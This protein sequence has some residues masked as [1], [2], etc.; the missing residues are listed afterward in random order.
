MIFT[1][2]TKCFYQELLSDYAH[3][4]KKAAQSNDSRLL[5]D[6]ERSLPV[7]EELFESHR[8]KAMKKILSTVL[9][10][11]LRYHCKAVEQLSAALAALNEVPTDE[12]PSL[13]GQAS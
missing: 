10:A 4:K 12:D 1:S 5:A 7:H 8:V 2:K 11:E 9:T 3:A 13:D 6:L